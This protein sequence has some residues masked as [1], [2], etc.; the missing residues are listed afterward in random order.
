MTSPT[1]TILPPLREILLLRREK[2]SHQNS[3][4]RRFFPAMPKGRQKE[5]LRA[6]LS[7]L[8]MV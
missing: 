5:K 3:L 4:Y 1:S 6:P 8:R 2:R 7:N